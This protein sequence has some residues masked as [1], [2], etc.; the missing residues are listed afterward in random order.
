MITTHRLK[1]N[2]TGAINRNR[3]IRV[4]R[5]IYRGAISGYEFYH[6][7]VPDGVVVEEWE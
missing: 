1:G 6:E 7:M 2:N 4:G 5:D 3:D